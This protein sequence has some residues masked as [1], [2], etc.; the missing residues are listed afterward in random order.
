[1]ENFQSLE[2]EIEWYKGDCYVLCASLVHDFVEDYHPKVG[3][4]KVYFSGL[5]ILF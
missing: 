2:F 1:M 3:K 5:K 4:I